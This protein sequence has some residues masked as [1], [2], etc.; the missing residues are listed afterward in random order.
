MRSNSLG[1]FHGVSIIMNQRYFNLQMKLLH[2]FVNILQNQVQY[3]H[4]E[5]LCA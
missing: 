2:N 5:H 3:T 1:S 4:I